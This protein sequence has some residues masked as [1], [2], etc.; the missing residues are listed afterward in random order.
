MFVAETNYDPD[1]ERHQIAAMTGQVEGII[2]TS[3]R[4][5]PDEL[6]FMGGRTRIVLINGDAAGLPR[7]LISSRTALREGI[8]HLV[9]CGIRCVYYVG[10]PARSWAERERLGV[11]AAA[12]A[13]FAIHAEYLRVNDGTYSGARA[14][15]RKILEAETDAVI[16]FDDV[17]AHGVLDGLAVLGRHVP[18]D[19]S[20]LGCD[21][22]LPIQIHPRLSTI[23]LPLADGVRAAM[24]LVLAAESPGEVCVEVQGVLE[25]RETTLPAL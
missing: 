20:V 1:Q 14:L 3:T 11:V 10:G 19:V 23:R 17:V 24:D 9:K 16:A 7:V 18:D 12:A 15:A 4:L 25:L 13:E 6:A 22:A 8:C 5:S 2:V 21:D